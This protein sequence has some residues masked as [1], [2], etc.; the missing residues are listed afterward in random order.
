MLKIV[1]L[2]SNNLNSQ[3]VLTTMA[4]SK[5]SK[6]SAKNPSTATK[7]RATKAKSSGPRV[8][9]GVADDIR[10]FLKQSGA[11]VTLAQLN[12]GI[13]K[14]HS[15]SSVYAALQYMGRRKEIARKGRGAKATYTVKAATSAKPASATKKRR[16]PKPASGRA[17]TVSNFGSMIAELKRVAESAEKA[18]MQHARNSTDRVIRAMAEMAAEMRAR[19]A[20]LSSK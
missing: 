3:D 9:T 5:K 12:E 8:R 2:L 1:I 15:A 11:P 20:K 6:A 17:S 19:A 7:T 10:A 18:V 13:G 14:T 16:G 4:K